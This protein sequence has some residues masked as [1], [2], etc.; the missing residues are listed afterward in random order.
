[1]TAMG[2]CTLQRVG[3]AGMIIYVQMLSR[4]SLANRW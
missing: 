4:E 3:G 2:K 1:M